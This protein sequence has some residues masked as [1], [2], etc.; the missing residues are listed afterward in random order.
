MTDDRGW[1]EDGTFNAGG[2][3]VKKKLHFSKKSKWVSTD[4]WRGYSEPVYA[5]A[6]VNDTGMWS[7]SP[8][9]SHKTNADLNKFRNELKKLGV[10]TRKTVGQTS[11]VFAV[12]QYLIAPVELFPTA[13][14]KV[15][16]L[17]KNKNYDW[18]WEV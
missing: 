11:N 7:D 15:H 2:L 8:S 17:L 3:P 6:G 1:G 13:K 16:Q 18:V 4:A 9:P 10:P 12:N 5:V 14:Q